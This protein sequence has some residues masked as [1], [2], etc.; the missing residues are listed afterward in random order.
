MSVYE[1]ASQLFRR[2][3]TFKASS[4]WRP[5]DPNR[6]CSDA[7]WCL[8]AL[9]QMKTEL[10]ATKSLLNDR[11]ALCVSGVEDLP[12]DFVS[13]VEECAQY[14]KE[15]Q[16]RTIRENI[17]WFQNDMDQPSCLR[18]QSV[19]D[20]VASLYIKRYEC[21][22]VGQPP[23]PL[24]QG[25]STFLL[26]CRGWNV[27][28]FSERNGCSNWWKKHAEELRKM[29]DGVPL[30]NISHKPTF[31]RA[32]SD[33]VAPCASWI[34]TG[35]KYGKVPGLSKFCS[36]ALLDMAL[37]LGL[38]D[39]I[40]STNDLAAMVDTSNT[41]LVECGRDNMRSA[42]D[43]ANAVSQLEFGTHLAVRLRETLS[44]FSAGVLYLLAGLFK[45]VTVTFSDV[46][47]T[48]PLWKF[49][50][51]D[52]DCADALLEYFAMITAVE[53][54]DTSTV[55]EVVPL[56]MLCDTKFSRFLMSV[57]DNILHEFVTDVLD[58]ADSCQTSCD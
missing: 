58:S 6:I 7:D 55:L 44:R 53:V 41:S 40:D 14:F 35:R 31:H 1:E 46:P 47:G 25:P 43:I 22:H 20:T 27:A 8:P 56:T 52:V 30:A 36:S 10:N 34:R 11:R 42:T 54:G 2:Q 9:Q 18:L 45:T 19:K 4:A 38:S 3:F 37:M 26:R 12:A 49:S 51:V 21:R 23:L 15:L 33:R 39:A 32:L 17:Q 28:S 48:W 50:D 29:L 13:Q 16:E 5:P 24:M 57:N